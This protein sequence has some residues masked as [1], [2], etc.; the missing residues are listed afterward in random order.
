MEISY[1]QLD[2]HP[3]FCLH[4]GD[5]LINCIN[6]WLYARVMD[7]ESN[8]TTRSLCYLSM[9]NKNACIIFSMGYLMLRKF[10]SHAARTLKFLC[11]LRI[12]KNL[13][14]KATIHVL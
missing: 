5:I 10:K 4:I 7:E 14:A 11:T 6:A 9:D 3:C 13:L 1:A 8:R 12:L 2:T